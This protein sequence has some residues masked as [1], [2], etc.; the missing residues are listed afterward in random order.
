[1]LEAGI[2]RRI[3]GLVSF[4]IGYGYGG[5]GGSD[6]PCGLPFH[7][8]R[9]EQFAVCSWCGGPGDEELVR[10]KTRGLLRLEHPV[11]E[12]VLLGHVEVGLNR[13]VGIVHKFKLRIRWDNTTRGRVDMVLVGPVHFALVVLDYKG[14]MTVIQVVTIGYGQRRQ[15]DLFTFGIHSKRGDVNTGLKVRISSK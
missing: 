10:R 6:T 13:A 4:F 15:Q 7:I 3:C 12:S 14:G 9:R 1:M 5:V 11:A 2:D 8:P